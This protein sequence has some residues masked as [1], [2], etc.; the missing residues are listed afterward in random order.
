MV[1]TTN[2][3]KLAGDIRTNFKGLKKLY[4][5]YKYPIDKGL[6]E[7]SLDL[8]K[9]G[10][11]DANLCSVLYMYSYILYDNYNISLNIDTG[12]IKPMHNVFYR[13]GLCP[14]IN[15]RSEL[16][17][18]DDRESVISL[19]KFNINDADSFVSYVENDFIGHRGLLS[20][21]K[22]IK[23]RIKGFYF[24]VFDN[25]NVHA[26]TS[27]PVFS[28]GQYFPQ[29]RKLSFS[30]I[31][32]GEGFL[33]K[34]KASTNNEVD[35]PKEAI[36]WALKGNTTKIGQPGGSGLSNI[37]QFC[38]KSNSRLR[39][40]SNGCYFMFNDKK[41]YGFKS[42]KEYHRGTSLHLIIDI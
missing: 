15:D 26:N 42:F 8:S 11:F 41:K 2:T 6:K 10:W 4:E 39:L 20:K 32:L 30:L 28:C 22:L 16:Y 25:V 38:M 18:D 13:N 35:T 29:N 31:D 14:Y 9:L 40:I 34:I 33:P 7:V 24:E 37:L 36:K 12:T 21:D 3:F 17:E 1:G 19:N 27:Y 5:C 23:D